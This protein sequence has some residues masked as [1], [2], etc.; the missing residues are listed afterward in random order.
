MAELLVCGQIE[1]DADPDSPAAELYVLSEG[2]G[3][4][5]GTDTP[6]LVETVDWAPAGPLGWTLAKRLIVPVTYRAAVTVKVTPI[7]DYQT[8]L[9]P[10]TKTFAAPAEET[11]GEVEVGVDARCRMIRARIEVIARNGLVE[12][13]TPRLLHNPVTANHP[14][15]AGA[16]V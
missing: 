3:Q 2:F 11:V 16:T 5:I 8:A 10:V 1:D 12:I 7:V 6:L 15:G 9:T 4:P 14:V 13:A